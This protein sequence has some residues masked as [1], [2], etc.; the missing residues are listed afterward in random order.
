MEYNNIII[1]DLKTT[2][3]NTRDHENQK[4]LTYAFMRNGI[5]LE[6]NGIENTQPHFR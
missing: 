1:K 4:N 6:V 3:S 5:M 2:N